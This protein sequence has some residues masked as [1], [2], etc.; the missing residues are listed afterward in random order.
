MTGKL[1]KE[2]AKYLC[3]LIQSLINRCFDTCRF[4]NEILMKLFLLKLAD[5]VQILKKKHDMLSKINYI[6]LSVLPCILKI[7]KKLLIDQLRMYFNDIF[8]QYLSRY[9]SGYECEDV[10]LHCVSLCIKT[11]GD[12][13]VGL[14]LLTDLSKS[15]D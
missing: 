4:S 11:L 14:A 12:G 2:G 13:Y 6:P 3:K 15:L 1:H 5:V 10:L 7:L 9:R 8:S